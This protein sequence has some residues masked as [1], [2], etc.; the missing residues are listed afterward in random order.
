M[1][2][3]QYD[4]QFARFLEKAE[5]N[6][7][8]L[9]LPTRENISPHVIEISEKTGEIS[10]SWNPVEIYTADS[11]SIKREKEKF[12]EAFL[13]GNS[14]NP[15]FEYS[16]AKEIF[17]E[18]Q[19]TQAL[20]QLQALQ[21]K[22]REW[23]PQT[24]EDR[25]F[26]VA[27]DR[28][29]KDDLATYYL[30]HGIT[31]Q[32]EAKI[33]SALRL[34]YAGVNDVLIN[35]AIDIYNEYFDASSTEETQTPLLSPEEQTYLKE[36][37]VDAQGIA[38]AFA[39]ALKRLGIDEENEGFGIEIST[40]ATAIDVRDKS[41]KGKRIFIP[42]SRN[43]S[44]DK[45]LELISHEIR[46]HARQSVNGE[47]MFLIGGGKLKFDDE[48]LYEGLAKR[49]DA[50]YRKDVFSDT[51]GKPGPWYTFAV[52]K[53]EAGASFFEIFH[54]Q[55]RLR[56][57]VATKTL[58]DQPLPSRNDI[59]GETYKQAMNDAWTTTYRV[60]RGHTDMTNS[61]Q[62][63][64]AKDLG[65]HRGWFLDE[66]L[67]A[68]GFGHINEAAIMAPGGLAMLAEFNFTKDDLAIPDQNIAIEYWNEVLK[69]RMAA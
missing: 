34:K 19:H 69:P 14:Y 55:L 42:A 56:L 53:A 24:R 10:G 63:A 28:K 65:Y 8:K 48:T 22:N 37:R 23:I 20:G 47:K 13:S 38:E 3:E 26:R 52:A 44:L 17:E 35:S 50:E 6:E 45:L 9:K 60:M 29:I 61:A 36:T 40:E 31:T 18:M 4:P 58:L 5:S 7:S 1:H 43:V 27:I 68:H 16:Y 15:T 21:K 54:D 57:H 30:A 41:K 33:S 51:V 32:D 59:D 64:M 62:Y 2:P 66:D 49:Y 11:E 46:G 39:W 25:L 12:F 67:R